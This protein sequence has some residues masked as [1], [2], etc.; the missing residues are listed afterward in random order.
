[1][2]SF[3]SDVQ[4]AYGYENPYHSAAHAAEVTHSLHMLIYYM[5]RL[6]QYEKKKKRFSNLLKIHNLK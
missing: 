3:V 5:S 6:A 2:E 4:N 1:M